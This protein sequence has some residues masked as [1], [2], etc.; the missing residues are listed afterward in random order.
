MA[1][2]FHSGVSLFS[3]SHF[4]FPLANLANIVHKMQISLNLYSKLLIAVS[5]TV[6]SGSSQHVSPVIT[7]QFVQ[8]VLPC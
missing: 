1:K 4:A 6:C 2:A 3:H 7:R 8:T 5:V